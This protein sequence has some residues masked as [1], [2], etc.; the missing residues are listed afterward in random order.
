MHA[1]VL[2]FEYRLFYAE[3]EARVSSKI[4]ITS[5]LQIYIYISSSIY[6]RWLQKTFY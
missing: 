2:Y 1:L 3:V 4:D 5:G 6:K